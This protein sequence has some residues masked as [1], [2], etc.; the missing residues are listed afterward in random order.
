MATSSPNDRVAIV[1]EL[2]NKQGGVVSRA[3][4][5]D[6]GLSRWA[7]DH[8]VGK[9]VLVALHPG[10]YRFGHRF[11]TPVGR[12]FA[13]QLTCGPDDVIGGRSATAFHELCRDRGPVKV[14]LLGDRGRGRQGV[15]P[16]RYALRPGDWREHDG[17]R[18]TTP[19]RSVFDV[20]AETPFNQLL[21][22]LER[23]EL[24]QLLD[25]RE[26]R[27]LMARHPRRAGVPKLRDALDAYDPDLVRLRSKLER[28]I[29]LAC[30]RL[31]HEMPERNAFFMGKER[32]FLWRNPVL[33]VEAD[34]RTHATV[35]GRERDTERDNDLTIAGVPT[36]RFTARQTKSGYAERTIDRFLAA[37]TRRAA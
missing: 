31:G 28:I 36:L 16:L 7:V 22:M 30:R 15:K 32:D 37:R 5:L 3:Q 24:L 23:A 1:A 35:E 4:L 21:T 20:A 2:A 12:L 27:S 6:A 11:I 34:G 29:T 10:V 19:M 25:V 13:A 8:R 18:V 14:V 26:L 33:V 17:L 9:G